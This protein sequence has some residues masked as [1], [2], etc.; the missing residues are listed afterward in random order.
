MDLDLGSEAVN[1][2]NYD[3]KTGRVF[4]QSQCL[5]SKEYT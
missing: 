5:H 3:C 4:I 2:D 1:H